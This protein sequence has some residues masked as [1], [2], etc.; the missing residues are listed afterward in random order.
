M[1]DYTQEDRE[2]DFQKLKDF[3]VEVEEA[4]RLL[5][6]ALFNLAKGNYSAA[7]T[8]MLKAYKHLAGKEWD[9]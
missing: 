8:L 5:G 1:I 2:K 3:L 6:Y 9:E 7:D 4:R